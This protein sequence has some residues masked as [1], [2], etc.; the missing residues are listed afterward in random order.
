[1]SPAKTIIDKFGGHQAI[2]EILGLS[3]TQVYRFTYSREKGGTGGAV[4]QRHIPTLLAAAKARDFALAV[5]DFFEIPEE[6]A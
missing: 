3:V 5:E 2:A 1:M 6:A 4:P